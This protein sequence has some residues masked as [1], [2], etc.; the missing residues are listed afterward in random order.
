MKMRLHKYG[1]WGY[2]H[3]Q[4]NL[5]P[6]LFRAGFTEADLKLLFEEN[7]KHF[8]DTDSEAVGVSSG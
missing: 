2:D 4:T 3:I 7:P 6:F 1:G 5:Y 8:L